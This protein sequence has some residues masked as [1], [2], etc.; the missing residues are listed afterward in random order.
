MSI[1][2]NKFDPAIDYELIKIWFSEWEWSAPELD[3]IP[4]ESYIVSVNEIPVA[5]SCF[6]KTDTSIAIMGFTIARKDKISGKS[7]AL[8]SLINHIFKRVGECGFKYLHYYTDSA[9]M[10]DRME[11]LGMQVTDRAS[12]YILLKNISGSNHRFYDE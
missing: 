11:K 2:I 12:A 7:E 1:V 5:F 8:D 4:S 10:V 3:Q 9:I 6:G